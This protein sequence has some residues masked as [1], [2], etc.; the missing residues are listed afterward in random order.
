VCHGSLWVGLSDTALHSPLFDMFQVPMC[1]AFLYMP[2]Y[3][4]SHPSRQQQVSLARNPGTV[5]EI[6]ALYNDCTAAAPKWKNWGRQDR[7]K[8]N[9]SPT[10]SAY[11]SRRNS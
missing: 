10:H 6:S 1:G 8:H 2:A 5:E 9:W 3:I 4:E 7:F 11:R